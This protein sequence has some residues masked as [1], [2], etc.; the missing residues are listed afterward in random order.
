MKLNICMLLAEPYDLKIP[1]RP[2]VMEMS[3]I[4][5]HLEHKVTWVMPAEEN[6]REIQAKYCGRVLV[7]TVPYYVGSS[8]VRK[9]MAKFIFAWQEMR[10]TDDII[11]GIRC[12][13]IQARDDIFGGLVAVYIKKRY[14]LPFVFQY[15]F[16]S[17]A[18]VSEKHKGWLFWLITKVGHF[19]L[20]YVMHQADLILPVSKWMREELVSKGIPEDKMVSLPLGV[21]TSLFSPTIN[22]KSIR[23]KYNLGGLHVIIYTGTLDR[24]RQLSIL[25]HALAQV[26]QYN[27]HVKLLILGHGDDRGSLERLV[28]DYKLKDNIIFVGQVPYPD[29][30]QFIASADIGISSVP[31]TGL[32]KANSPSKLFEYMSMGK[33]VIANEE[34]YE[35]REVLE[36]SGGG[37]LVPFTSEA[38]ASAIIE[39][40]DN[41]EKAIEMGQRGRE[42]VVKNRSYEILFQ[43]IEAEYIKLI[44]N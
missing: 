9:I 11:D 2:S 25:I 35:H 32:Y 40:L 12:N 36:E 37:I 41:P 28:C 19:V 29:V 16:P 7:F 42:W 26:K 20:F 6:E 4:A 5:T 14:K 44:G 18:S 15:S 27:H 30:P 8:L 1:A 17:I 38:F 21:N 23:S 10:L 3:T 31:P 22:R 24:L 43:Q 34:I 33:P 39:L 13:I